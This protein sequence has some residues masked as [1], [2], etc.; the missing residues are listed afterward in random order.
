MSAAA[1][2]E[3]LGRAD[4]R[5]QVDAFVRRQRWFGGRGREVSSIDVV[6]VIPLREEEAF[7]LW[8]VLAAVR[9]GAGDEE[10]YHLPLVRRPLVEAAVTSAD[11]PR[12]VCSGA[13]A[14]ARV[15]I[16]DALADAEAVEML[17]QAL[18]AAGTYPGTRGRLRLR[19]LRRP[20]ERPP[21]GGDVTI[22]PLA[23]EQSNSTVVR[24]ER[25]LLKCLRRVVRGPSPELEMARALLAAGFD[26][27]AAPLA[28]AEYIGDDGE[29][30]LLALVQPYLYGGTEGWALALTSLR[31]HYADAEEEADGV[32]GDADHRTA[33][34]RGATFTPEAARLGTLT[35]QMHLAMLDQNLP[36][37]LR[38]APVSHSQRDAWAAEMTAELDRLLASGGAAVDGVRDHRD[39]IAAA[40]A[41]LRE[42]RDGGMSI[43][44][45]GD[46]HLAQ[47]LRTDGGWTV[48]DLEGEPGRPLDERRAHASPLSDVAGMLR[49]FDYAAA[50]AARERGAPPAETAL[51]LDQGDAW[52]A[53]NRA[54]FWAAYT[55]HTLGSGL[56]PRAED[57]MVMLRAF[58]LRKAVYEVGYELGHRPDWALIPLRFLSRATA[59]EALR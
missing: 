53:A 41:A 46:Y 47:V 3:R 4:A 50:T 34:A 39:G 25:E 32:A 58:E 37:E 11:D 26:R 12:L 1:L 52:T 5:A 40:F 56:L 19:N 33:A 6:E 7:A 23:R 27:V 38:A 51:L 13:S 14:G 55:S 31:V 59:V 36:E 54:A 30:T 18:A 24:G 8:V 10:L 42:L 22:R 48:L 29:A 35:A 43:R 2:T 45:H 57:A 49:S 15:A 17:W 16:Y 9:Y 20:G 21:S 44:V 28:T